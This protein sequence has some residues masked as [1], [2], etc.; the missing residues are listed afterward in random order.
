MTA[1]QRG[2]LVALIQLLLVS[3][4]G[5]VLLLDRARL[6]RVWVKTVPVD[7]DTPFRGRYVR[8]GIE[9]DAR[10]FDS[11]AD[12]S[13]SA[14]TLIVEDDRLVAVASPSARRA[15]PV[16]LGDDGTVTLVELLAYFI[17][18]DVPDPSTRPAGE[19]L[20]VEVTVP[21]KGPPRPIRLG[22]RRAGSEEAP[23]PLSLSP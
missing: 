4:L 22:I 23:E 2:L 14:A 3:S 18:E 6:P 17:P 20:W 5:G 11:A 21:P 8:L 16:R 10:G 19:E 15:T 9:A 1:L 7:P 13:T 12:L